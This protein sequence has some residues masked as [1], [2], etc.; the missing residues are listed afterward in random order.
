MKKIIISLILL[1]ST[2]CFNSFAQDDVCKK[3]LIDICKNPKAEINKVTIKCLYDNLKKISPACHRQVPTLALKEG[4]CMLETI[5]YCSTGKVPNYHL[6]NIICLEKNRSKLL[7]ACVKKLAEV[8]AA[9]KEKFDKTLDKYAQGCP[10][11]FAECGDPKDPKS[12]ACVAA[13]FK[14]N[15]VTPGCR[16]VILE[17]LNSKHK[18]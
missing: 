8:K 18:K 3:D 5:A 14:A 10:S 7:P 15:K 17:N 9:G 6:E 11:E 4:E 16:K 12:G 2:Y 1:L 13:K